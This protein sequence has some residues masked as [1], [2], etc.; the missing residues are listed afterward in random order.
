[1]TPRVY[2][3]QATDPF[4]KTVAEAVVSGK[5]VEGFHPAC[6]PLSLATATIYL[7]TRRAARG[8]GLALTDAMKQISG[9]EAT[10][11]PRIRTLGDMDDEESLDD[12]SGAADDLAE[13][14]QMSSKVID[15]G[16]RELTLAR[17]ARSWINALQP[18]ERAL[19]EQEHVVLPSSSADALR[20]ARDLSAFMDQMET[21]EIDPESIRNIA[22]DEHADWWALTAR[23]LSIILHTWPQILS[24]KGKINPARFRR[25]VADFRIARLAE[26]DDGGG[27]VIAAGST[28]SIPA[29]ARLLKAIA[30]HPR[31]AVVLPGFDCDLPETVFRKLGDD[32]E[33]AGEGAASTHPQFAMAR[34]IRNM[35]IEPR[36]V[37]ILRPEHRGTPPDVRLATLNAAL[38]PPSQ[39][40]DWHEIR[41]ELDNDQLNH[42]FVNVA[43]VEARNERIE[44][45]TIALILR[46]TLDSDGKTAALVTPDRNIAR[47][48]SGELER[49]GIETDDSAGIPLISTEFS[50]ACRQLLRVV[51]NGDHA[52]WAGFF[53]SPLA[54]GSA[55]RDMEHAGARM[56]L[57]LIRDCLQLPELSDL[58][59]GLD[60]ARKRIDKDKHAHLL[61]REMDE[62][63]WARLR[64]WAQRLSD[65]FRALCELLKTTDEISV[66]DLAQTLLACFDRAGVTGTPGGWQA[67]QDFLAKHAA[68]SGKLFSF[69]AYEAAAVFD[70]LLSGEV[71]RETGRSHPR[72]QILGT[73]EARLQHFDR[74]VV[75]GLNEG[76]WPPNVRNDPFLNRPMRSDIGLPLPERRIGLA[77]HDFV[78]LS[79]HSEVFYTRS[80]RVGDTPSIACRW[81]QRLET[82]AGE[83]VS[84]TIRGN[85]RR[86]LEMAEQI[87]APSG[88]PLRA[89]RA[90]ARPPVEHRPKRLSITEIE[91]WIRDPYAIHAKHVLGLKPFPPLVRNADP[92]LR[93]SLYHG[94]F[95]EFVQTWRGPINDQATTTLMQIADKHFDAAALEPE[96]DA[97]WRPRFD[98]VANAFLEW[99]SNRREQVAESH[100]EVRGRMEIG[101][102]GFTLS[103]RADRID[104]MHDGQ[105]AIIDYK[106]GQASSGP[107][108]RTLDP[109]LALTGAMARA[110]RFENVPEGAIGALRYVPLKPGKPVKEL[111]VTRSGANSFENEEYHADFMMKRL[112]ERIREYRSPEQTYISR[113]A[114]KSETRMSGDYDHLARVREWS[115]GEEESGG[116]DS[117]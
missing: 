14:M 99:E 109:Q 83:S 69:P 90:E 58:T 93:G 29:T 112:E 36:Q 31:G 111:D 73:L 16:E 44:A 50:V 76:V 108:A 65:D 54:A 30:D 28:G 60:A 12:I 113:Y 35:K 1:M 39:T 101:D 95:A 53:K 42:S 115:I 85:G 40:T 22:P 72:L 34:L 110:G 77:A 52:C 116:E 98:E 20:L 74:V 38:L 6:D 94:I 24:E 81:L 70:A 17:L 57:A 92:A 102:T 75:A 11:L 3:V 103:G 45:L 26:K 21:E 96:I 47:R 80:K 107:V 27:P 23:F 100:C 82:F 117:E 15:S 88:K 7:P 61:V 33:F 46:E 105:L 32:P 91:T 67:M 10:L 41:G 64:V 43:L 89:E 37:R 49:F 63:E 55:P 19:F 9:V 2:S 18:A 25:Q 62:Q 104:R 78:Q 48:V 79:G 106:T 13:F 56:E 68:R 97:L 84:D 86:Y 87:D 5:L 51:A 59:A 66:Q 4:L 8:M 114:P 71:I